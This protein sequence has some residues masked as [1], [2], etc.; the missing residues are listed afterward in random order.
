MKKQDIIIS[1]NNLINSSGFASERELEVSYNTA[2]YSLK[3]D[4][5]LELSNLESINITNEYSFKIENIEDIV[6]IWIEI[7]NFNNVDPN[8]ILESALTKFKKDIYIILKI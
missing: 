1:I 6:K 4:F 2:E 7:T 8:E 5:K 3:T